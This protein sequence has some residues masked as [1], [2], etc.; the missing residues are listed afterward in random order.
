[1]NISI[2]THIYIHRYICI[3][4]DK[5][6][7]HM[8]AWDKATILD[9]EPNFYARKMKESIHFDLFAKLETLM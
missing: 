3:H 9:Y 7:D 8:I 6:L 5:H 1:M 2:H 4:L